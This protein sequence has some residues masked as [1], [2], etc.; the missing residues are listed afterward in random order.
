MVVTGGGGGGW[1]QRRHGRPWK[2]RWRQRLWFWPLWW[3]PAVEGG[4]S[5]RAG[6]AILTSLPWFASATPAPLQSE[7]AAGPC[8]GWLPSLE[9]GNTC[10]EEVD[11][12]RHRPMISRFQAIKTTDLKNLSPVWLRLAIISP[13]KTLQQA[14]VQSRNA[15]GLSRE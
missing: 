1:W 5:C 9:P 6:T 2:V 8:Q 12:V 10:S 7:R 15:E 14:P 13:T 3:Q 11:D 4:G